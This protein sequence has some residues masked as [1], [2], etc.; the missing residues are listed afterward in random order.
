MQ[1]SAS[2][3]VIPWFSAVHSEVGPGQSER[4]ASAVADSSAEIVV[5]SASEVC[6]AD[7][8][9]DISTFVSLTLMLSVNEGVDTA[10]ACIVC[11]GLGVALGLFKSTKPDSVSE[12]LVSV[13]VAV[14]VAVG[15][16]VASVVEVAVALGDALLVGVA[17]GVM[18]R[19]IVGLGVVVTVPVGVT[20]ADGVGVEVGVGVGFGVGVGTP[21]PLSL[22]S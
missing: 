14:D 21:L 17:L 8:D 1:N 20:V 19:V 6:E 2:S 12:M 15:V 13:Y 22:I 11:T 7:A 4:S 10:T 9:P 18:P 16:G 3:S 5:P